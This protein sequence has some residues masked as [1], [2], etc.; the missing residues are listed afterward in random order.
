LKKITI[1]LLFSIT[2][3]FAEE[4]M[5]LLLNQY[6][7]ESKLSKITKQES[8]GYLELYTRDELEK[9]QAHNLLDVFKTIPGL[10]LTKDSIGI[11]TF[12][13]ARMKYITDAMA[14]LYINDHDMTSAS[15]GSAFLVWADMPIEYIDHIEVYKATSSIEFGNEVGSLIVR[16]Y[17]KKAS[18]EEGGKVRLMASDNGG[19]DTSTYYG[20][21]LGDGLA[22]FVFANTD[23][24]KNDNH[25]HIYNNKIY[26]IKDNKNSYTLFAN[27]LYKEWTLDLGF[28]NK[29]TDAYTG[30]GIHRTPSGDG[31]TSSH[32]YAHLSKKFSNGFRVQLAYD[33]M[34]NDGRFV[35]ENGI[36][37]FDP[38]SPT[39][40]LWLVNDYHT[41]LNDK[42]YSV[43]V[44]KKF[45]IGKNKLLIGGFYKHKR[46]EDSATLIGSQNY[47]LPL[48]YYAKSAYAQNSLN[49]SSIYLENTYAYDNELQFTLSM[50]GD[51]YRYEKQVKSQ[52]KYI[53]RVGAVKNIDNFQLR[54][55]FV[56][57]YIP[58]NFLELYNEENLPVH[59]NPDLEYPT[60]NIYSGSIRYQKE[61]HSFETI[62]TYNS[63]DDA[64]YLNPFLGY[65]NNP[66]R[67]RT[68]GI[69]LRYSYV[70]DEDNKCYLTYASSNNDQHVAIS[71]A[72][73]MSARL[74]NSYK[75]FDIY[76]ELI[77]RGGYEK[78][79]IRV[80]RSYDYTASIKYHYNKDVSFGIRG[81]NIF[82]SGYK[83]VYSGYNEAITIVPQR[84]WLNVEVLF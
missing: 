7:Q 72:Y 32:M 15:F 17:T 57:T 21:D 71:P 16:V 49:L 29:D 5:E 53:A 61:K 58:A 70:Y 38:D 2:A 69:E 35:D 81:D 11:N 65:Q 3:L 51:F 56:H 78:D 68:K 41:D 50:K 23:S 60:Q 37:I 19:Y 80:N 75:K 47:T 73:T 26:T 24:L 64:I 12:S 34:K 45:T 52:N 9:M 54:A 48:N 14:R 30:P 46:F 77:V 74:F 76:N 44:D 20:Q 31:I 28:Y 22:Y 4:S 79:G 8:A 1:F 10:N 33:H 62:L 36:V 59:V 83:Q 55:F 13:T 40:G 27:L 25:E 82:N 18:R 63:L 42:V 43:V 6:K 66:N 39:N 67:V 84:F